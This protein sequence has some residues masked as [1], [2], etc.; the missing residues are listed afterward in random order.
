M[1][2]ST[3]AASAAAQLLPLAKHADLDGGLLVADHVRTPHPSLLISPPERTQCTARSSTTLATRR[4]MPRH[5]TTRSD[6]DC[7]Q[8]QSRFI[9]GLEWPSGPSLGMLTPPRS[10]GISVTLRTAE[11]RH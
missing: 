7:S 4:A 2:A 5:A 1:V 11:Q 6:L 3:V 8:S 10:P 9:G